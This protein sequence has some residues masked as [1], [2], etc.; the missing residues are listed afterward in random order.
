[1]IESVGDAT[2]DCYNKEGSPVIIEEGDILGA[3]VFNPQGQ[4]RQLDI[5]GE[6]SGE[7]LLRKNGVNDC[8]DNNI[9][10]NVTVGSVGPPSNRD[11]PF[12]L[13]A[14]RRLHLYAN[15]GM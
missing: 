3:C 11:Q 6:V 2:F 13:V 1:M 5:V 15:I 4:P 12:S 7:S 14:S 9:P 10:A 8:G